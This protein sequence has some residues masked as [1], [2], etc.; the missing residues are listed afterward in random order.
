MPFDAN[1]VWHD[2]GNGQFAP[3]GWSTAK[4]LALKAARA[5]L[6]R[7][8]IRRDRSGRA[9]LR[10]GVLADAG[11]RKGDVVDVR[12]G[13]DDF[14]EVV[15]PEPKAR[16]LRRYRV[17]WSDLDDDYASPPMRV[18]S[19]RPG[20]KLQPITRV[21]RQRLPNIN[22]YGATWEVT[23]YGDKDVELSKVF[24]DDASLD[25]LSDMLDTGA[26]A[27]AAPG[28]KGTVT[29]PFTTWIDPD[30]VEANAAD[31]AMASLLD[32]RHQ[33]AVAVHQDIRS[34]VEDGDWTAAR[35]GVFKDTPGHRAAFHDS[36]RDSDPT[37]AYQ[38]TDM[39]PEKASGLRSALARNGVLADAGFR[40]GAD[41]G[42][43][44][45]TDGPGGTAT[46]GG[47]QFTVDEI[48]ARLA[49]SGEKYPGVTDL[50]ARMGSTVVVT[51]AMGMQRRVFD[52]LLPAS[53][54]TPG[55]PATM[56]VHLGDV[57]GPD[58]RGFT[59]YDVLDQDGIPVGTVHIASSYSHRKAGEVFGGLAGDVVLP[60]DRKTVWPDIGQ[61]F[62]S[63]DRFR[64]QV[65][66]QEHGFGLR[67]TPIPKARTF[68]VEDR[69]VVA[70][71]GLG[72]VARV[73]VFDPEKRTLTPTDKER[74][75]LRNVDMDTVRQFA[76]ATSA[77]MDPAGFK[78]FRS[79]G[80]IADVDGLHLDGIDAETFGQFDRL[81]RSRQAQQAVAAEFGDRDI[82]P[83]GFLTA[84][85]FAAM[86][87]GVVR[88][89]ED[90]PKTKV[91]PF[92]LTKQG[93]ASEGVDLKVQKEW[94][95]HLPV[96]DT[97]T[98]AT[99]RVGDGLPD[100]PT[101]GLADLQSRVGRLYDSVLRNRNA[102]LVGPVPDARNETADLLSEMQR[103][104][105][106]HAKASDFDAV[107]V[108]AS[109]LNVGDS[110]STE[111]DHP[112]TWRITKVNPAA[113]NEIH[114]Y[115][116]DAEM[117]GNP[118]IFTY[119]PNDS[120]YRVT[121]N[122]ERRKAISGQ[123]A[124]V[125]TDHGYP[126]D[127][128]YRTLPALI[129]AKHAAD[130]DAYTDNLID[131]LLDTQNGTWA[132]SSQSRFSTLQQ[133]AILEMQ[134]LSPDKFPGWS[135][136]RAKRDSGRGFD[137]EYTPGERAMA[138]LAALS[139]YTLT[140]HELGE[141]GFGPDDVMILHRGTDEPAA[142]AAA[143]V[144]DLVWAS[145][146]PLASYA[147]SAT[148]ANKFAQDGPVM[149]Q[150]VPRSRIFSTAKT[151]PGTYKEDEIVVMGDPDGY[152]SRVTSG[153]GGAAE[154]RE[155]VKK[156]LSDMA[157]V[158]DV[159]PLAG[160]T[161]DERYMAIK[162]WK[163]NRPIHPFVP[164][165]V[166]AAG[167]IRDGS[168]ID[169]FE[170]P[171]ARY[172]S[173]TPDSLGSALA[174]MVNTDIT[175]NTPD[176]VDRVTLVDSAIQAIQAFTPD[177]ADERFWVRRASG[178]PYR[179]MGPDEL[180]AF[181]KQVS[182]DLLHAGGLAYNRRDDT[183]PVRTPMFDGRIV[184]DTGRSGFG[185]WWDPGRLLTFTGPDAEA[186]SLRAVAEAKAAKAAKPRLV[187]TKVE[188]VEPGSILYSD[189]GDLWE[190]V[191]RPVQ[192]PGRSGVWRFRRRNLKTG[193]VGEVES[194]M[195]TLPVVTGPIVTPTLFT[196]PVPDDTVVP[197]PDGGAPVPAG[198]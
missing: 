112:L 176:D 167:D 13:D 145:S 85:A 40:F 62:E 179:P 141:Q 125:L 116:V 41:P 79:D 144:G 191:D 165:A 119:G 29:R 152:L 32:I 20:A 193:K 71:G 22:A 55:V 60:A 140:Q 173:I 138:R 174:M 110:F 56:K 121:L 96:A 187:K 188:N 184:V 186:D 154:R 161:S 50:A 35:I 84:D 118:R 70:V 107:E 93:W 12:W 175:T 23:L 68:A 197:V 146:N 92:K 2:P 48:D 88:D 162:A 51:D 129:L 10:T 78:A 168:F 91:R 196:P 24:T 42:P 45:F 15:L 18:V 98:A 143:D 94:M 114:V 76:H 108:Q 67:L 178:D 44:M 194:V 46:Y 153:G 134:G 19:P 117:G 135:E 8:R 1:D 160:S 142:D 74:P 75:L 7:D 123:V 177:P 47:R 166:E 126:A 97:F 54:D 136:W 102:K 89:F 39:S 25:V 189:D 130:G 28:G 157:G 101:A 170:R 14:A 164:D 127:T 190:V 150:R 120:L 151:G 103:Q 73:F 182:T 148:V 185:P 155:A 100:D 57:N 198:V 195:Y 128:D 77:G 64:N 131:G 16:G 147:S 6:T 49:A 115:V 124:Q 52:P 27:E 81:R 83:D 109:D 33:I 181:R 38:F 37:S 95:S 87:D 99:E 106:L 180:D 159:A 171:V 172:G 43:V 137:T 59:P 169:R 80:G 133:A 111:P 9:R 53:S 82:T 26:L 17:K 65:I 192:V 4:A 30:D 90:T 3:R 21:Q 156:H 66:H 5:L 69:T 34:T 31:S 132:D 163:L 11:V 86:A 63:L 183:V 149:T 58:D 36:A 61:G 113:G 72:A 104:E 158:V 139:T 105:W 122:A